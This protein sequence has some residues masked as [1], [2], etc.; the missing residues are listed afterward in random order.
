MCKYSNFEDFM[1]F[2]TQNLLEYRTEKSSK[3]QVEVFKDQ[4]QTSDTSYQCPGGL[5]FSNS[6]H[7]DCI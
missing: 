1:S 3:E 7:F 5:H 2:F 4:D 6:H